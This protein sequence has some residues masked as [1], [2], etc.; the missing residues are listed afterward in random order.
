MHPVL[1]KISAFE[2]RSYYVLWAF[3]LLMFLY[4][5]YRRCIKNGAKAEAVS[6]VLLWVYCGGIF[7]AIFGAAAEKLPLIISGK[8]EWS[9]LLAG[10]SSACFGILSGGLAGMY[11]LRREK[12]PVGMFADACALPISAMLAVGRIGCLL[13]GCCRGKI[14]EKNCCAIHF[15]Q[16]LPGVYRFPSQTAEA[17]AAG[18]IFLVLCAAEKK[19]AKKYSGGLLFALFLIMYGSYRLVFDIFREKSPNDAFNS[20]VILSLL[21]VI[22]GVS[23]LYRV[24][25]AKTVKK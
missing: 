11:R 9:L 18:I 13:E 1:F 17:A 14:V 5:S 21:A 20:A 16:D 7:G 2:A 22:V 3:A 12:L 15:P 23:W 6:S 25:T 10:G 8:A 4:A 19:Y 24:I